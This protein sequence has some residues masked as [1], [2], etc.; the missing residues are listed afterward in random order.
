MGKQKHN[1]QKSL[2][3]S[4]S[5]IENLHFELH[6]HSSSSNL[7]AWIQEKCDHFPMMEAPRARVSRGERGKN[8]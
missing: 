6:V 8:F 5:I 2:L 1:V 3:S 7:Q 4:Q